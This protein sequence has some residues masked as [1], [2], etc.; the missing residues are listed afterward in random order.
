MPK[1]DN[2]TLEGGYLQGESL[3]VFPRRSFMSGTDGGLTMKYV[4]TN[5]S[6]LDYLCGECIQGFKVALHHPSELPNMDKHFRLPLNHAVFVGVKPSLT[7][8]T[9]LLDYSPKARKCYFF[10]EKY[11]ASYKLYTQQNC[12][13]E[14]L[15]N[16]TLEHCGC[17]PFYFAAIDIEA[18]ICGPGRS[19]CVKESKLKYLK[20]EEN[21][22]P[23]DQCDCLPSCTSLSYEVETSQSDWRWQKA[24]DVIKRPQLAN[25]S[26]NSMYLSKLTVFYKDQQFLNCRRIE[27]YGFL[28][29]FSNIGGLLGLLIG[30]S[31]TSAIEIVYFLTL[32][33]ICN[34][35]RYGGGGW[36]GRA[37]E[38]KK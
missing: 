32:R 26:L 7:V 4:Y 16:Y 37:S 24:M 10:S 27:M 18:E 36:F 13:Y 30:F 19:Q 3:E 20:N 17:I 5:D 29:F 9:E 6:H 31:V 35:K 12:L 23:E 15:A 34:I 2:W 22:N 33:I 14:C 1:S 38:P 28:D 8:S 25:V 21:S 11:L